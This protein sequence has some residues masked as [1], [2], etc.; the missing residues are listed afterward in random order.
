MSATLT[1]IPA[2]AAENYVE[3]RDPFLF[4]RVQTWCSMLVLLLLAD[5]GSLFTVARDQGKGLVAV[6]RYYDVSTPL[7]VL[8]TVFLW[9]T[10]AALIVYR[11]GPTLRV[12]LQQKAMLSLA[13]LAF[14][15]S[16]W[17]QEP[18]LTFRKATWLFLT[19]TFAWFFASCYPTVDQ[20]RLLLSAGVII[21]VSSYA[22][23]VLLPQYGLD[24]GGEWKGVLGQKNHLGQVMLFLFSGLAIRPIQSNNRMRTVVLQAALPLGLIVMSRSRGSLLLALLLAAV[25]FYGPFLKSRRRDQLP[26]VLFAM[27]CSILCIV[28][29]RGVIFSFLGR[30]GTLTGRTHEWPVL[31]N[32]ALQH[33]W[34]GYGFEGFWTG[35][36]DSLSAMKLVGAAM[37]GADSGYLD[38]ILQLG[39]VGLVLWLVVMLAAAKDFVRI[40]RGA[41]VPLAAYWYAGIILVIFVGSFTD[42]FFPLRGSVATF[43]FVVA[44]AGLRGI[45]AT[46]L[47]QS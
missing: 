7:L 11:L 39:L 21:A 5:E 6:R 38:T 20:A 13:I 22:M 1:S 45:G 35:A 24:V 27:I 46:S 47:R 16:L 14:L 42:A 41:L 12:M 25:R 8:S 9:G 10:V 4:K 19:F 30:D 43:I 29:G 32:F 17:S 40:V 33:L 31:F 34:L 44:C 26:F 3:A 36:G 37:R 18:E 28:I 23:A 2:A 15:S